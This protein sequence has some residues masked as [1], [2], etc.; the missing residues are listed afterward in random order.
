MRIENNI[1]TDLNE[2]FTAALFNWQK[3]PQNIFYTE[4]MGTLVQKA[5]EFKRDLIFVIKGRE[6]STEKGRAILAADLMH[7]ARED[8]N[9]NWVAHLKPNQGDVPE[10]RIMPI[11]GYLKI[12]D[13]RHG[14]LVP[15]A[16]LDPDQIISFKVI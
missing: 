6:E 3:D 12:F 1:E 14:V 4:K 15:A 2:K 9:G 8:E 5:F 10:Y 16:Y 13:S 11:P 7:M